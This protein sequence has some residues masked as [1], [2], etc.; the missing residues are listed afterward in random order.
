M[1]TSFRDLVNLIRRDAGPGSLHWIAIED[2]LWSWDLIEGR[3]LC[4]GE[5]WI[6]G[7]PILRLA[8]RDTGERPASLV[9]RAG[10][11][12][13]EGG[14]D[15]AALTAA[16]PIVA[17]RLKALRQVSAPPALQPLGGS[18]ALELIEASPV[19]YRRNGASDEGLLQP[20]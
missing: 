9:L 4:E 11:T 16:L 7:D 5:F 3:F 1:A 19:G 14:I 6:S 17:G 10:S 12:V 15:G 18:E 20:A 13:I 2:F 8:V